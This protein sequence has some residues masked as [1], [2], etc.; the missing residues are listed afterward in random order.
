MSEEPMDSPVSP[1]KGSGR[2]L[3]ILLWLSLVSGTIIA[4]LSLVEEICLA[5]ACR[6]TL[7]FTLFGIGLGWVGVAYFG[8]VL[9]VL[10]LRGRSAGIRLLLEALVFAGI[11]T[12]LRLLWIQKFVIGAWCPFCVSIACT[13][14]TAAMLLILE[15]LRV[16]RSQVQPVK[17][18]IGWLALMLPMAGLGLVIA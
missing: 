16:A 9:I 13:V 7:S 12:E 11:G 14:C 15:N 3:A 6:D 17:Y 10:A 5:R 2:L 1:G 8:I 4:I 18:F